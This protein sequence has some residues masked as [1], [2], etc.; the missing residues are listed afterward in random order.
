MD[1]K[2]VKSIAI[3]LSSLMIFCISAGLLIIIFLTTSPSEKSFV[4]TLIPLFLIWI[5]VFSFVMLFRIF[6]KSTN[7]VVFRSSAAVLASVAMLLTMFSALG[8]L[9]FFDTLLLAS[10][11][12]L[13]AFYFRRS[14][15]N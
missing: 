3:H 6:F 12:I 5:S 10:L 11:A 8:Q 15:P 1:T 9:S 4:F 13:G 14:W 7:I 2:N